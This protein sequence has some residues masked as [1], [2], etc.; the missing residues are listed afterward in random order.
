[1]EPNGNN[2]SRIDPVCRTSVDPEQTRASMKYEG[3]DYF[4]CSLACQSVF[5]CNPGKYLKPRNF[6]KRFL[7]RLVRSSERELGPDRS[8]Y[9]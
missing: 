3:N 6:M 1:M 7:E 9:P 2:K 5:M 8:R 4:F